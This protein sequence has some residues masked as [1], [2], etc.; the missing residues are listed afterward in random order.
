[1]NAEDVAQV[2]AVFAQ[3]ERRRPRVLE[4]FA[5]TRSIGKAAEELGMDVF[6]VDLEPLPGINLVTDIMRMSINDLPWQPDIVWASPPCTAFSVASLG[7]HW[8]GGHR[9][10]IPKTEG[11]KL[12]VALVER[13]VFWI[14]A[15]APSVWYIEN[16]RGLL[17]KL[18]IVDR[19]RPI[20][21]TVTY[22]R[23]G[24][25]RMKPTDVWTN[26][27]AWRP[28]LMCRNGDTCHQAAP[29][30]SRTGT[31]GL[32]TARDRGVIPHNLCMEVLSQLPSG[33]WM[34]R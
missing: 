3:Y 34:K 7:H 20:H 30:G 14:E 15:L 17:R 11:A 1:M 18:G 21:H 2:E 10:Y 12:C 6:S 31:Q 23:Y 9:A 19:L 29:R 5:G 24:D 22:C 8:G 33:L 32:K 28:K 4:L 27:P 26:N 25:S 13:T 16:P